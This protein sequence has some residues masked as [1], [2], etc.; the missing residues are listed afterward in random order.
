[1]GRADMAILVI[2]FRHNYICKI[3]LFL[4]KIYKVC[5]KY[6]QLLDV[7]IWV[8]L[9]WRYQHIRPRADLLLLA[10]A[11]RYEA[12]TSGFIV[13]MQNVSYSCKVC[14]KKKKLNFNMNF[15]MIS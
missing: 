13:Y 7:K 1:M 9:I 11:C 12:I 6:L 10:R 15:E 3:C 8:G 2:N 4:S 14:K 5:N